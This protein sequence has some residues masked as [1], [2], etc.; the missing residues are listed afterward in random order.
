MKKP[1]TKHQRIVSFLVCVCFLFGLIPGTGSIFAEGNMIDF[2]QSGLEQFK[3]SQGSGVNVVTSGGNKYMNISPEIDGML[4]VVGYEFSP[5]TGKPVEISYDFKI[6]EYMNNGT[7]IASIS[8]DIDKFLQIEVKDNS[9][10]YE[11]SEGVFEKLTESCTVNKWYNLRLSI[12]FDNNTYSVFIDD[13]CVLSSQ[14]SLAS[15][16]YASKTVKLYLSSKYTPGMGIDNFSIN[17]VNAISRVS[18]TGEKSLKLMEGFSHNEEYTVKTFDDTN[19]EIQGGPYDCLVKPEGMGVSASVE[20]NTVSV[21]FSETA[22]SGEYTLYVI[23]G[24]YVTSTKIIVERYVPEIKTINI[25]GERKMAYGYF[26]NQYDYDVKLIDQNGNVS[27]SGAVYFSFEGDVPENIQLDK[28][29]GIITVLGELPKDHRIVLKA[30]D[31]SDSSI[32]G[33]IN[34]TLEDSL[35]YAMD[36][37]R[38]GVIKDHIEN[39]YSY[40]SDPYNGTPLLAMAIDRIGFV[41]A[42]WTESK[43]FE[44]TPCDQAALSSFQKACDVMYIITGDETYRNRVDESN[45]YFMENFISSTGLPYWGGHASIRLEDLGINMDKKNHELKSHFPYMDSFFRVA[46]EEAENICVGIFSKHI[47]DW[48]TFAFNRH[49]DYVEPIDSKL[50]YD[51]T[52][53]YTHD[54]KGWSP[55]YSTNLAFAST[56]Y[57]SMKLATDMYKYTGSQNALNAFMMMNRSFWNVSSPDPD[58]WLEVDQNNTAG[59]KGYPDEAKEGVKEILDGPVNPETGEHQWWLLD[60][61]PSHLQTSTYGDRF[62]RA[63]GED[64]IDQGFITEEKQWLARECYIITGYSSAVAY[65]YWDFVDAVGKDHPYAKLVAERAIRGCSNYLR[66]AYDKENNN[67]K[68]MLADGTDLTGFVCK[69]NGYYG[70]IGQV[71]TRGSGGTALFSSV[72]LNYLRSLDYPEY[73]E[74]SEIMWGY[75]KNYSERNEMGCLGDKYP[76]DSSTEVNLNCTKNSIDFVQG[77]VYLYESTKNIQFLDLA[78]KIADNYIADYV[79][80]GMFTHNADGRYIYTGFTPSNALYI[81]TML[82]ASIRGEFDKL[83]VYIANAGIRED[84]LYL[85]E[86]GEQLGSG[87]AQQ[88]F[89][90]PMPYVYVDEIKLHQNEIELKVGESFD[91]E[92]T[93]YP[94]DAKDKSIYISSDNLKCVMINQ[95]AKRIDAM[96]PGT[97]EILVRSTSDIMI[98]DVLKVTVTE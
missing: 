90:K 32:F 58:Y 67:F 28:D 96:S 85:E 97:A 73:K 15:Y 65:I 37:T 71:Y 46:P 29:T 36:E 87:N 20:N 52:A 53:T 57:E 79:V 78:R 81:M 24:T 10:V 48:K 34:I 47:K 60:P 18:I 44:Y 2:E 35:T 62:W 26:E 1:K 16:S 4:A 86:T 64:L 27:D 39:I 83:P 41:P 21:D 38:F 88:M 12:D 66:L 89:E 40:A 8:Q 94:D 11:S 77:L 63:R 74:Q 98:K 70:G 25:I 95:D 68:V 56:R 42:T 76:G 31:A 13:T 43:D 9:F 14:V 49:S 55:V 5:Q 82:E 17:Q 75:L 51:N 6:N 19:T 45:R 23:E 72:A 50:F 84:L 3:Y 91:I 7:T 59:R 92:Y 30:T 93:A 69:R 22:P 80:D 33:T 61:V 54:I